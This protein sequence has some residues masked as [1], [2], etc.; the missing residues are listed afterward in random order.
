MTDE[1]QYQPHMTQIVGDI[2]KSFLAALDRQLAAAIGA[3][4]S[5]LAV[6]AFE[7]EAV[8][9]RYGSNAG[10]LQVVFLP[11]EDGEKPPLGREWTVYDLTPAY[12]V[13]GG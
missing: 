1:I 11:L 3:G 2:H 7:W 8:P 4:K 10:R 6:S 9:T 5:G 13:G 12:A